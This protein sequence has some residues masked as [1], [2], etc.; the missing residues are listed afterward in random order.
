MRWVKTLLATAC[1]VTVAVGSTYLYL[2]FAPDQQ[3]S[4]LFRP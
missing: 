2:R 4:V 1:Y 3:P